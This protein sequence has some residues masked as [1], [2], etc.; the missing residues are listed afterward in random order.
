MTRSQKLL[1]IL[2]RMAVGWYLLYQG[3]VAFN[4]NWSLAPYI[5]NPHTFPNF[6]ASIAQH[7]TLTYI[8]FLIKGMFI[9]AGALLIGGIFVRIGALIG[10]ALMLFFYFPLLAF[11]YVGPGYYLI[12]EH[13]LIAIL[14]AYLFAI[15]AGEFFGIGT[16]FKFSRY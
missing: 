6:Y 10:M 11:P 8:E 14:L 12:D 9:L 7:G 5:A 4:P 15:R 2:L 3:I 16:M 13:L 1:V